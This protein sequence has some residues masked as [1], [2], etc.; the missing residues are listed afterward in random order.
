M[1]FSPSFG[2]S[3]GAPSFEDMNR[4]QVGSWQ[5]APQGW[6]TQT[7]SPVAHGDLMNPPARLGS[8]IGLPTSDGLG[9]PPILGG[10]LGVP[11][12]GGGA[13]GGHGLPS[14]GGGRPTIGGFLAGLKNETEDRPPSPPMV[15]A[16]TGEVVPPKEGPPPAPTPADDGGWIPAPSGGGG[17]GGPAPMRMEPVTITGQV[18]KPQA[19]GSPSM[20]V[21]LLVG[22]AVLAALVYFG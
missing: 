9:A 1:A 8:T 5:S 16:D 13:L 22:G 4:R 3:F 19:S 15:L 6:A 21:P 14:P 2:T 20:L 10:G 11:T 12:F 17:G 18:P 7:S